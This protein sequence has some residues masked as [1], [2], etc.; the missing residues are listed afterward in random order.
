MI[1]DRH[2][3]L[4]HA[5]LEAPAP[6]R[7][8]THHPIRLSDLID[9]DMGT[10]QLRTPRIESGRDLDEG[11][12]FSASP[13]AVLGKQRHTANRSGTTNNEGIAH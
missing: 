3:I 11:L 13:V 8:M 6:S 12:N 7:R 5:L 4:I 1:P 10:S 2:A 9:L